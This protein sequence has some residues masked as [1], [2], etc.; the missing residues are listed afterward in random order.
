MNQKYQINNQNSI[1]QIN[2]QYGKIPP[3]AIDLEEAVLGALILENDAY[4]KISDIISVKSFYKEE[5]QKIYN[6]IELLHKSDKRTDLMIITNELRNKGLIEQVG[7]IMVIMQLSSKVA[8]AAH[9]EFHARIIKQKFIQRE[10]IRISTQIQTLAYDDTQDVSDLLTLMESELDLLN[11]GMNGSDEGRTSKEVAKS[12]L[13]EIREDFVKAQ[14]NQL[15]GLPTGFYELN[16]ATGGWKSPNFIILAARPGVGKTSLMLKFI[17]V[18]AKAGF[19]CNVYGYEMLSEDLFRI[20]L[21]GEAEIN[22][23]N[24]RDGKLTDLDWIKINNAVGILE[25]LPIIWYDKSDIKS[26]KIKTNT[27]KNVKDGKCSMVFADY[28][29]IIPPEEDKKNR[30]EQISKISRNLK[31]ITTQ[32]KIPVMALAQLNRDIEKRANQEPQLSDLRE[33]GS[34][35]QD[36]DIVIFPY[37]DG[38]EGQQEF[39]LKIA[40]HRRGKKGD[41]EIKANEDMTRFW[42]ETEY[43]EEPT[44]SVNG[45]FKPNTSF[46][47]SSERD[48]IAPF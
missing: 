35:E 4:D 18:A 25:K 22:R 40:K 23:S 11:S 47:E 7:G 16:K 13:I 24:L 44:V 17:I 5:H 27:K 31:S 26:G 46:Y 12:A 6:E 33:S 8:N 2:A 3:Q 48:E 41:F 38:Q 20:I 39:R 30:E 21:S 45:Q 37:L 10:I 15:S 32:C 42:D 9:I 34:L 19:W 28:L 43:L 36:S 1:D 14:N 29:Q